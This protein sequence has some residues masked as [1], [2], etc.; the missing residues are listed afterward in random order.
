MSGVL[1]GSWSLG[2]LLASLVYGLLFNTIGWRGLLMIGVLPAL[3]VVYVRMF[4][5]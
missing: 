5:E 3:S 1:Q 4:V 2:F